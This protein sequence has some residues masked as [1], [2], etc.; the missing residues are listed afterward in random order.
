MAKP[1]AKYVN[2]F[3]PMKSGALV[4]LMIKHSVSTG[5]LQRKSQLPIATVEKAMRGA[6]M[7]NALYDGLIKAVEEIG[8]ADA[9]GTASR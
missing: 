6:D 8:N 9:R 7:S 3:A 4:K 1:K 2:E 5:A